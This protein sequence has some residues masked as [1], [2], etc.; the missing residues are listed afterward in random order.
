MNENSIQQQHSPHYKEAIKN[1]F[2]TNNL[3]GAKMKINS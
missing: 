2:N 3:D 1:S